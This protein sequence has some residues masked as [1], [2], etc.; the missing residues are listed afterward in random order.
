MTSNKSNQYS[1]VVS[2]SFNK[3]YNEI[4]IKIKEFEELGF[5][6]L[7]PAHSTIKNPK[8]D[9]VI[10]KS[11]DT[12][13][14]K[15]LEQNH[16][17]AIYKADALYICNPGGYIG[18][19]TAMELGWALGFGKPI[20]LE[21]ISSNNTLK[22]FYN[23]V[24]TPKN[25][26]KYLINREK[27][28]F[29]KINRYSTLEHL[30]QYISD[31]VVRRGFDKESTKDMFLLMVEEI[32]ELAK[33]IRKYTGLKI[34]ARNKDKYLDVKQEL[35]DIFIYLLDLSNSCNIDLF[36]AF[37]NKEKMNEKRIW[38]KISISVNK[39]RLTNE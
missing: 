27:S 37:Y 38:R 22:Y 17:N 8:E 35:A 15:K 20:F 2:G 10:L 5:K 31:I 9:F 1:V 11:D 25:V 39:R 29:K 23:Q 12:N 33:A 18:T 26:L 36:A 16:L 6:V 32:G 4:K 14:A 34:D 13:D 24:S 30:Q 3:F 19:S 28:F 7:S 21:E